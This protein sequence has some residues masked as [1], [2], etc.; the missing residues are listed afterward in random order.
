MQGPLWHDAAMDAHQ[1]SLPSTRP[2]DD[3]WFCDVGWGL[4]WRPGQADGC[5]NDAVLECAWCGAARCEEHR[6]V[7]HR[8]VSHPECGEVMYGPFIVTGISGT[9]LVIHGPDAD[10]AE[11]ILGTCTRPSTVRPRSGLNLGETRA[12]ASA[13]YLG[14][15]GR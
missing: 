9:P 1:C 6:D 10:P 3:R 8:D 7:S 13:V 11:R 5:R 12:V 2:E 4:G 14:S 15:T